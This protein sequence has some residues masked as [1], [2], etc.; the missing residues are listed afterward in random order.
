MRVTLESTRHL[1]FDDGAPV[2]AASALA[3]Y[4][5]GWLVA[6]DDATAA[7]WMRSDGVRRVRLLPPVEGHDTFRDADGTARHKPDLAA[8]CAL[9]G[10]EPAV[11]LLGSGATAASRRA[12]VV[13]GQEPVT[14]VGEL[15]PLYD[16]VARALDVPAGQLDLEGV[17]RNGGVLRWFQHGDPAE[18]VP[19]GSVDVQLAALLDALRGRTDPAGVPLREPRRYDLGEGLSATDAVALPGGVVLLSATAERGGAT[20]V[21]GTAALALVDADEVLDV[22]SLP[23]VDGVVQ[24]V[25][26]LGVR[27]LLDD[28]VRLLAVVDAHDPAAPSRELSLLVHW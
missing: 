13:H 19:N 5:G 27:E 9:G 21:V 18:G 16:A 28:G 26:G 15:G 6:Q 17:A 8:A 12:V 10:P 24:R 20:G 23:L 14:E 4:A 1:S 11:L 22:A 7:A 25:E 2:T 3:P